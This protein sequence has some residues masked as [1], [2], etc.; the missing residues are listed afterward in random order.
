MDFP[1]GLKYSKDYCWVKLE[2]DVCTVGIIEPAVKKIKELVFINLPKKGKNIKQGET[3]TSLEAIKWS[4][5]LTSP[6]S[7]KIIEVNESL[8]QEPSRINKKPYE[9]WIMKVK[10]KDKKELEELMNSKEAKNFYSSL[11]K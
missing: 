11:I 5:H 4:G 6:V 8:F 2:G 1:R 3:Y 10:L 7:G 9:C